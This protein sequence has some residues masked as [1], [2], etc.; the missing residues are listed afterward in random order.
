[1]IARVALPLPIDKA[2]D[3]LI[4][5]GLV[6][7][8]VVGRRVRVSFHGTPRWGIVIEVLQ[9]S[10]HEGPLERAL[11]VAASPAF[12]EDAL[13][14]CST[15]ADHYLAPLG[16]VINRTLPS[17]ISRRDER[18]VLLAEDLGGTLAHLDVRARRAPRQ[19]AVLRLLLAAP[20]PCSERDLRTALGGSVRRTLDRL[21]AQ[22][23][24]RMVALPFSEGRRATPAREAWVNGLID[25]LEQRR[26]GVLFARRRW[27]I[28]WHL[29]ERV[30][31][32][33]QSV[34][35]LVPEILLARQLYT[36]FET[37]A[38][39]PIALY[40]SGLSEG[41]RGRIWEAVRADEV[42]LVVG[43][44]SALFLPYQDLGLIVLDEEQDRA[45]K[46]DEMLPYYHARVAAGRRVKAGLLLFG[47]SA[48]S[49]EA[50]YATETGNL[51]L[52][53]PE[54]ARGG[55]PRVDVV[56]MREEAAILTETLKS[57]I[58]RTLAAGERVLLGVNRRGYFQ[59]IVCKGCGQPLRCSRC[60]TNLVYQAKGAQLVCRGCGEGYPQMRCFYCGSR[61]LRFVG[62]GS[63]RVEDAV[64]E[65]FPKARVARLDADVVRQSALEAE[66]WCLGEADI[67]VA[68]PLLAKGP[69]LPRLGLVGVIGVD[70]LLASPNFR[71]AEWTYQYLT[72][73]A[74]RLSDGH[75]VIQ[76]H[77][78]DH[79]AIQTAIRGDYERF[80]AHEIAGRREFSYP[81]FSHLA[82][83]IVPDRALKR[84]GIGSTYFREAPRQF[85][86]EILG[87]VPHPT[88]RGWSAVLIKGHEIDEL[89]AAC[90]AMRER[91]GKV[92]IDLDPIWV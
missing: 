75:V 89:R 16:L 15:I 67:L 34:L 1:M 59:A 22:K 81:P 4:P 41:E 76:T 43:T 92:E 27:D 10:D 45:Y 18:V 38:E 48:P 58:D 62:V 82:F 2:F 71:A 39:K 80:Y 61:A 84:S 54:G 33:G 44:R 60:G 8:V 52:L 57:A 77:Y 24:I 91:I 23:V 50:F 6:G 85:E 37:R 14:F 29:A 70:A 28:Y 86:V 78:P 20:G 30:G 88:R 31:G 19:A 26:R 74:G 90:I 83:A 47:S 25:R 79:V 51:A 87:P 65:H 36:E 13:A 7:D 55:Q 35:V 72:G 46:Q 66:R 73:L 69:P 40:H 11:E 49:L 9:E 64:K 17:R 3:F 12:S 42:K 63:Q 32:T 56:D 68:T 53:R 5:E 21:A